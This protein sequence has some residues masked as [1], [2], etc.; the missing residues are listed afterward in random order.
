LPLATSQCLAPL[1]DGDAQGQ[2]IWIDRAK[3][4]HTSHRHPTLEQLMAK[5]IGGPGLDRKPSQPQRAGT[6]AF[7]PQSTLP[8]QAVSKSIGLVSQLSQGEAGPRPIPVD[9]LLQGGVIGLM[10]LQGLKA[11]ATP[12]QQG[13]RSLAL[14]DGQPLGHRGER[15][16]LC[17]Q[18]CIQNPSKLALHGD[19][20]LGL[21][22]RV[23]CKQLKRVIGPWVMPSRVELHNHSSQMARARPQHLHQSCASTGLGS[24]SSPIGLAIGIAGQ[25]RQGQQ[26]AGPQT[27]VVEPGEDGPADLLKTC[28]GAGGQG[29]PELK[30]PPLCRRPQHMPAHRGQ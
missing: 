26:L 22:E 10:A 25:L 14:S 13:F 1:G 17:Q 8:Q 9:Q 15:A 28:L 7:W 5:E 2:Q 27:Q 18:S 23:E 3:Q 20:Q 30:R 24:K 6:W 12:Q 29:Q 19:Q 16:T 21:I 11:L 4:G